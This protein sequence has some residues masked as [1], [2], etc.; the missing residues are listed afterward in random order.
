[1]KRLVI[2]DRPERVSNDPRGR[3]VGTGPGL[4]TTKPLT[5]GV[6]VEH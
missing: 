1:M 5:G 6:F 4:L 3:P 2:D